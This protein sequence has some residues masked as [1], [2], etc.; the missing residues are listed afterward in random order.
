M[1]IES[2]KSNEMYGIFGQNV[3]SK[4]KLS[5]NS[6]KRFCVEFIVHKMSNTNYGT[7]IG[8]MP[9][10]LPKEYMSVTL[11]SDTKHF[12]LCMHFG[13]NYIQIKYGGSTTS[14]YLT[15]WPWH[16]TRS[17]DSFIF[18]M[19]VQSN[20]I[21]VY[22]NGVHLP[23]MFQQLYNQHK[24]INIPKKF[25]LAASVYNDRTYDYYQMNK[26]RKRAKHVIADVEIKYLDEV[27]KFQLVLRMIWYNLIPWFIRVNIRI[28][29][30]MLVIL[31]YMFRYRHILRW[32]TAPTES[33]DVEKEL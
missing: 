28:I 21:E 24:R 15:Q 19:D 2:R 11:G 4:R 1:V 8:F 25:V 32:S 27:T 13:V 18:A 22:H 10:P 23:S 17:G 12:A 29:F 7:S 16:K 3:L 33:E 6:N 30:F 26:R 20:D 5:Q 9:H 31:Y 14:Y